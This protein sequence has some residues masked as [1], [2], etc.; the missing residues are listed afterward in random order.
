MEV[1]DAEVLAERLALLGSGSSL[2]DDFRKGR[3]PLPK[4]RA[5][6]SQGRIHTPMLKPGSSLEDFATEANCM[7]CG[8]APEPS[9]H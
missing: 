2:E 7:S 1:F 3:E 4:D 9:C 6:G 5:D 8:D